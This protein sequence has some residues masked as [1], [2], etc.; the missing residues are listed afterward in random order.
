MHI[1]FN[2]YTTE[3]FTAIFLHYLK[4]EL[5]R[6][7]VKLNKSKNPR[8]TR[9]VQTPPTHPPI[10]FFFE[11]CETKKQHKKTQYCKKEIRVGA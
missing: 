9:I 8:K 4:L 5:P 2:H 7:L 10:H 6:G 3:W 1:Y 11:T